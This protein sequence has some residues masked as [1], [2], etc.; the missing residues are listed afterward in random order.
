LAFSKN[1]YPALFLE[2]NAASTA[3]KRTYLNLNRGTLV[4][5]V[6]GAGFAAASVAVDSVRFAFV[7]ASALVLAA[8]AFLTIYLKA[9][10]P[11]QLWYSG[12]AVAESVKSMSWRYMMGADP[13]FI[14]LSAAEAGKK[15][16]SGLT[17]IARERKQLAPALGGAFF[18]LPQISEAMRAIRS[19][20]LDER[21]AIY[22]TDRIKSQRRW[23]NREASRNRSA[24][25]RYFAFI[26]TF[27]FCAL[28]AAILLVGHPE[29]KIKATGVFASL[30]SALIAWLQLNQ[31]KELAQSYCVTGI[32][33]G[34]V[35]EQ[36]Q[37]VKN[38]RD[39]SDF[40]GDA[41]NAISR[42][43][44]LWTARRDKG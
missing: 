20:T 1:D 41:E 9:T 27:Q 33:L 18:E 3:A 34:L 43:H 31:H 26:L 13:Y 12:R 23:Y 4:L 5:L 24:D 15:L 17:D 10:R 38:D 40:V 2:A 29:S 30:A 37:Y 25:S 14:D 8:S 16:I 39:L 44:T 32:D 7:V 19:L 21:K 36:A 6:G 35:Q 11:E 42:E 28:A 22:L